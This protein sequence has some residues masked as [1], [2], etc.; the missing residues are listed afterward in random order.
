MNAVAQQ[1]YLDFGPELFSEPAGET[2]FATFDQL[3]D[4]IA[5]DTMALAKSRAGCRWPVHSQGTVTQYV[6]EVSEAD[7]A[8]LMEELRANAI[9]FDMVG[10]ARI[11]HYELPAE[12]QMAS[13]TKVTQIFLGDAWVIIFDYAGQRDWGYPVSAIAGLVAANP[14]LGEPKKS[15]P[16]DGRE[17]STLTGAEALTRWGP[18]VPA[19]IEGVSDYWDLTGDFSDV[20]G[21]DPCADLSWIVLRENPCCTRFSPSPI[22]LFH[23]GEFVQLATEKAYALSSNTADPIQRISDR[24]IAVFF[25]WQGDGGNAELAEVSSS[26]FA[27]DE[28]TGKV[29]R[30]G[31]LPPS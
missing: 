7:R 9:P 21:Y 15:A 13:V 6:A 27:W 8:P 30:D 29:I 19:P 2:D 16:T 10:E 28:K 25:M 11:F 1:E 12:N 4:P 31:G 3:A 17:C 22:L 18:E 20:S 14:G 23:R 26:L 5:K 24:S